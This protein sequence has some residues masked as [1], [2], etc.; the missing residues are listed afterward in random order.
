MKRFGVAGSVLLATLM[1][2]TAA[3][4]GTLDDVK[5]RGVGPGVAVLISAPTRADYVLCALGVLN[6]GG[7][8]VLADPQLPTADRHALAQRSHASWVLEGLS[9]EGALLAS[10][11]PGGAL[12]DARAALVIFTSGSSGPPKAVVL[13]GEG[14][15]ANVD[16]ILSY[17]PVADAPRTA[18]AL[19]LFYSYALV[20]QVFTALR[21]GGTAVLLAPTSFPAEQLAALKKAKSDGFSSVALGLRRLCEVALETPAKERPALHY[22]ASAGGPLDADT[23]ALMK[24]AFPQARLFNQYGLTEASPRVSALSN[25]EAAFEAG[26]C[27]RTIPGVSISIEGDDGAVCAAGEDGHVIVRG[28]SVMLGYLDDAE[29]TARVLRTDGSLF[30][31][32]RGHLDANGFL[33]V[34]GRSDGVVKVAGVRVSLEQVSAQL[35]AT[36]GVDVCVVGVEDSRFGTRLVAFVEGD[37]AQV[38]AAKTAVASLSPPAR[39]AKFVALVPLPRTANGKPQLDVLRRHA[40]E[41]L[42]PRSA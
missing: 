28:P 36:A 27:G 23:R 11:G 5:A 25:K 13:S 20:G 7:V 6:S 30:T 18:V 29:A 2:A 1:A 32:D 8:A 26:S 39:P 33:Y 4:A 12:L 10:P 19:P 16:A 41:V 37:D 3:G 42:G 31:N 15:L 34:S 21:V 9:P 24:K 17:L 35:R 14:V 38:T 40:A 22:L